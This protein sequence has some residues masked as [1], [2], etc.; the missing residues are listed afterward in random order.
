MAKP[1]ESQV[2]APLDEAIIQT[3]C[4]ACR[5][6][7]HHL[8]MLLETAEA[9]TIPRRPV[10]VEKVEVAT[11]RALHRLEAHVHVCAEALGA[12]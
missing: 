8:R 4:T 12:V 5:A 11:R 1:L 10:T 9:L 3:P 7:L 6:R 2:G